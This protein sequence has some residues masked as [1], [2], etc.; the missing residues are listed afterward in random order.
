MPSDK[1]NL[2]TAKV[3]GLINWGACCHFSLSVC[4]DCRGAF[5]TLLDS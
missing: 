2:I 4:V 3:A 1:H 5:R